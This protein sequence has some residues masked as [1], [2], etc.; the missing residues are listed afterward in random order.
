[1]NKPTISASQRLLAVMIRELL[2]RPMT[3]AELA[4]ITG[5]N[6]NTIIGYTRAMRQ[7]GIMHIHGFIKDSKGRDSTYVLAFGEGVDAQRSVGPYHYRK[8][9]MAARNVMPSTPKTVWRAI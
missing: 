3:I 7:A 8:T 1:L 6:R 2:K 4:E 9:P 5:F